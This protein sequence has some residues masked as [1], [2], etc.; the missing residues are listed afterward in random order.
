MSALKI[1]V[2]DRPGHDRR[3][4]MN[5]NKV[6]SDIGWKPKHDLQEGLLKTV[7]WYLEHGA[8]VEG[9]RK[10]NEYQSWLAKNYTDRVEAKK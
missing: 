7:N 4:A 5:I 10:Q 3:Y 8:W 2:P 1:F 6:V 9:L